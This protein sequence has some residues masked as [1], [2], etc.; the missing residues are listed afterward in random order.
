MKKILVLIGVLVFLCTVTLNSFAENDATDKG[1]VE[2][3]LGPIFAL[4]LY[5]GNLEATEFTIGSGFTRFNFGYFIADNFSI[6]GSAYFTS[7]KFEG[8]T[9]SSTEFGFGPAFS[10]YVPIT[11]RFLF[12]VS[13]LFQFVSWEFPGDIDRSSEMAFGGGIGIT[14]LI[15]NNLGVGSG[16][17]IVYSPNSKDEGVEVPD[18][19]YTEIVFGLGFSVYI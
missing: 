1:S 17:G 11:D 14:Y 5:R 10:L 18:S 2:F 13:G 6:G 12:Y 9:E 3:G 4:R 7:V 15:T 8:A 19:S 16:F